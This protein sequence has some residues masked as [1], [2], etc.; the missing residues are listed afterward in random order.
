MLQPFGKVVV[1][2]AGTPVRATLNQPVPSQS[3]GVQSFMV[4]A[5]PGNAGIVYVF[6]CGA[7]FAG[8]DDRTTLIYCIAIL[9]KPTSATTGPFPSASFS[10][11]VIP[12]GIDLSSIWID[13]AT[14]NDGV[15]IS[16][17]RG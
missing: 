2:S 8:V 6:A 14:S 17:T 10:I 16:G 4:Q 7:S 11:P 9:P 12:A 3:L 5:L 1:T 15:I 13:A